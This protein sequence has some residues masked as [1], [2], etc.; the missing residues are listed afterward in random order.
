MLIGA[1]QQAALSLANI[2]L[3]HDG[4]LP[5][6]TQ[7]LDPSSYDPAPRQNAVQAFDEMRNYARRAVPA[8]TAALKSPYL[9]QR[10]YAL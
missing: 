1:S 7:T 9:Y 8:L 2:E 5:V 4:F 6:L 3:G 10:A